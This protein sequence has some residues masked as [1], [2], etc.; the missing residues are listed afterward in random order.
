MQAVGAGLLSSGGSS[1]LPVFGLGQAHRCAGNLT[2]HVDFESM[3]AEADHRVN[4]GAKPS[5][6]V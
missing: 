3:Q 1:S 2:F 6:D 5:R 4:T